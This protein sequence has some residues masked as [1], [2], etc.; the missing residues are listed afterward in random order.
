MADK[1]VTSDMRT[2]DDILEKIRNIQT[3]G[4]EN[5]DKRIQLELEQ[6]EADIEQTNA[7]TKAT[8]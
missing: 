1:D 5:D 8:E 6:K 2:T 3:K 7:Q 4:D